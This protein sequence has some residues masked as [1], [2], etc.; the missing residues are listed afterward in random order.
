M[1]LTTGHR[2]IRSRFTPARALENS[3]Y[4][5]RPGQKPKVLIA[6]R[7]DRELIWQKGRSGPEPDQKSDRSVSINQYGYDQ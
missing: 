2:I 7:Q 3:F 4:K 6:G 1:L 5:V